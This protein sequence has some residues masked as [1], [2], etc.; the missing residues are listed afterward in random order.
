MRIKVKK[1]YLYLEDIFGICKTFKKVTKNL[2][3]HVI[4]KTNDLQNITYSSM[5]DDIKVT[6]NN[7]YLY[8]PNSIPN[9]ETQVVFNDA[10]Q[11]IMRYLL[12]NIRQKD[13]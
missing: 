3:F 9:V 6:I 10:T 8:V 1:G 4:F 12:M 5:A 11:K 7:L 2:R 13:E